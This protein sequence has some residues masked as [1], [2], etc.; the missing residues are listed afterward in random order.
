[1]ADDPGSAVLTLTSYGMAERSRPRGR[2]SSPIVALW[3]DAVRGAREI[4]LERGA[5]GV[6][7][8]ASSDLTARRSRD[9]RG[10]VENCT[11]FFDVAVY[12]VH[13]SGKG[14]GGHRSQKGTPRAPVLPVEE[15][16]ILMS[17]A[18]AVAEAVDCAPERIGSVLADTRPGASWRAELGIPEPSADLAR[19]FDSFTDAVTAAAEREPS[20]D[21]LIAELSAEKPGEQRVERFARQSL[22]T[23][24]EQRHTREAK[25]GAPATRWVHGKSSE[26]TYDYAL[27]AVS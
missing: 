27:R 6:L 20:L 14:S 11:E 16:T 22:R 4:P 26:A 25:R 12:Q 21:E 17:W 8:T 7:L 1:L 15:R 10:P 9:G 23:A 24:L 5:H 19:S 3:K 2:D 13:A 18:E